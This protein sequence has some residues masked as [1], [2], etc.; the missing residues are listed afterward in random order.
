MSNKSDKS[1]C[2][3]SGVNFNYS[4]STPHRITTA[5]PDSS[6]KTLLDL[7]QGKLDMS[8]TYDNLIRFP[9]A[10]F[11][12]PVTTWNV[13]LEP[14]IDGQTYPDSSWGRVD[15]FLPALKNS[16]QDARGNVNL[17]VKGCKSGA[18]INIH[19]ENTGD[20]PHVIGLKCTLPAPLGHGYNPAWVDS[21]LVG[22]NLQTGWTDRADRVL[23][24]ALGAQKYP[25]LRGNILSM[26]WT[27]NPGES[28]DGQLVRP[29]RAYNSDLEAIRKINWSAECDGFMSAWNDVYNRAISLQIPDIGVLNAYKACLADQFIMREPVADGY[30]AATP[31]TECYRAPNPIEAGITA[32]AI[33]QAGLHEESEIGFRMPLSQQG[34]NGNWADPKGW[35][36]LFWSTPG[37]KSWVVIQHY[38]LT[39]D[40]AYLES[41][42]P[43]MLASSRF[44]ESQRI[45]TR[46]LVDGEKSAEYG[47][48]PRGQGDCGLMNDDDFYGV[49]LPHNIWAVYGDKLSLEAAQI[50]N[51]TEDIQE[52]TCIYET[53]LADLLAGLDKGAIQEDGY[54]WIPGIAHK[55]SG[56][57]WGVLNALAPCELLPKDHE[58]IEGT[59]HHLESNMGPGGI[60]LNMGWMADGLWVAIALDNLAAVHLLRD[61]GDAAA[62]YLYA[63]LNHATPLY[64]W[65]EERQQDA[66]T[67]K[68]SGDRQHLWTPVSVVR[69]IRDF[70]VVEDHCVL[71]LAKGASRAWLGSGEEVGIAGAP[72]HFGTVSYKMTF[73]ADTNEVVGSIQFPERPNLDQVK[74]HIRLP[75]GLKVESVDISSGATIFGDGLGIS[76]NKPTGNTTFRINVS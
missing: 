68:C 35:A 47:L 69:A 63:T 50:L 27:L 45:R 4:F 16:Y 55:T 66:G 56:S 17:T 14:T 3:Q 22:D 60:P 21:D 74:L 53:G 59:L 8:W 64:T 32:V 25:V 54:R 62:E 36:H 73:N 15:G 9:L 70:M 58:L 12:T 48:M 26:E 6:D 34:D 1:G 49:F 13:I 19:L 65:C 42:F 76:W 40:R 52:L 18:V 75:K 33:D 71:E 72:T 20:K 43:R 67:E 57:R 23:V 31:G 51:K 2:K 61:N 38:K 29:Y 44:Q 10:T 30:I 46:V 5:L 28:A 7:Y 39:Q 37:F 41:M 11:A 24:L